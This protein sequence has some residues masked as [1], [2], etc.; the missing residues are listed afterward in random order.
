MK[1]PFRVGRHDYGSRTWSR[2]CVAEDTRARLR[3]EDRLE[4][5]PCTCG[6]ITAL[7]PCPY[8]GGERAP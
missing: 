8:C 5:R 7:N 6:A 1:A 2:K 4:D 3:E